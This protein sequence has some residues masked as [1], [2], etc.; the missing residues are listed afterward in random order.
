MW[1]HEGITVF[2]KYLYLIC[3][4]VLF[5]W[6]L[7]HVWLFCDSM[8][9]S[10][11]GSSIHG[12][13]QA[14]LL[15]WVAISFSR[16]SSQPR[17]WTFI[18]WIGRQI[19]YHRPPVDSY[20]YLISYFKWFWG[21]FDHLEFCGNWRHFQSRMLLLFCQEIHRGNTQREALCWLTGKEYTRRRC[22]FDPWVG[23][24]PWRKW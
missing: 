14:R 5:L 3:L 22:R 1:L 13:P 16:G 18:S 4:L 2:R 15:E 24:I 7:Y 6:L 9:Y 11:P 10:L 17:D 21:C 23:K 8:N 12:I 20:L 19:I